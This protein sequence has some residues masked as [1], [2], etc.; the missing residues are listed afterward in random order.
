MNE[1]I[2]QQNITQ[3]TNLCFEGGGVKGLAY[4]GAMRVFEQHNILSNV[5]RIVGTSAGAINALILALGYTLNEQQQELERV[6]F[7]DFMDDSTF[8]FRDFRRLLKNYGFYKGDYFQ[9]WIGKLIEQ[10]LNNK[11]ATFADLK[12]LNQPDLYIC[13]TNLSTGYGEIFSY[14]HNPNMKL[15]DAVRMSMSIPLFFQAITYGDHEDT[16]VDGGVQNNYPVKAFDRVKYIDQNL[17]DIIGRKTSYYNKENDNFLAKY[18][19]SSPYIYNK[20]TLGLR[21]DSPQ[22]ISMFRHGRLLGRKKIS[23]LANYSTALLGALMKTQENTHLHTD[24]WHRTVYINTHDVK[25]TDFDITDQQ[26]E[27]LIT[28]GIN[29]AEEYFKWFFDSDNSPKNIV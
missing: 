13:A 26:K 20:Q 8:L 9:E 28:S 5:K 22:E 4:I 3:F 2:N 18:P 16:Y 17:L 19:G 29:S 23:N 12:Q 11:N 21:L 10:K 7:K 14:E 1:I 27:L 24:D 15:I 6:N 25:T